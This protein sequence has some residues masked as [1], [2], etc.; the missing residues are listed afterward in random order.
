MA[1]KNR[2]ET[3]ITAKLT[4]KMLEELLKHV[5]KWIAT[6]G[7]AGSLNNKHVSGQ[8]RVT[9]AKTGIDLVMKLLGSSTSFEGDDLLAQLMSM[10]TPAEEDDGNESE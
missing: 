2:P 5:E 10:P 9:A 4:N 7:S 6:L 8:T 1:E 3:P